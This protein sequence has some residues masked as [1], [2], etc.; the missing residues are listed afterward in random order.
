MMKVRAPHPPHPHLPLTLT[1]L[2]RA[3][4][5][6]EEEVLLMQKKKRKE[7]NDDEFLDTFGA[8]L[9]GKT[10]KTAT[11]SKASGT[12]ILDCSMMK[13]WLRLNDSP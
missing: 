2:P 8:M 6:E 12:P 4:K 10:S 7:Q 9:S 11:P 1:T 5:E 13:A 3:A